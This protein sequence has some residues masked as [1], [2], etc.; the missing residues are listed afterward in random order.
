MVVEFA[1]LHC[2]KIVA[3]S[4]TISRASLVLNLSQPAISLQIKR[5][6]QQL[7]KKLFERTNRGLSLTTFGEK[8]LE[9]SHRS[10]EL[11]KEIQGLAHSKGRPTGKI[12]IGTYT[13]ASSYLLAEPAKTFLQNNPGTCI[14]YSYDP[15]EVTL[16]KIRSKELEA[17]VLSDFTGDAS[18]ESV[19]LWSD[20]LVYVVSSEMAKKLPASIKAE[21]VSKIDFLSYPLRYDLCYRSVEKKL[22]RYLAK[23]NVVLESTSFDTLKQMVLLGAG[24]TFMPYYLVKN[25]IKQK[26]LKIIEIENINFSV[27][28]SYVSLGSQLTNSGTTAFKETLLKYF[29][30]LLLK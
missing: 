19:K 23:T 5:L 12:R 10:E 27:T 30:S 29:K 25:E 20:R 28:F 24:A 14:N 6:E 9:I 1:L 2:L 18:L 16:A 17:A 21:Q 22:G 26:L 3:E 7:G 15:V 8:L 13:T 11:Q 4:Q